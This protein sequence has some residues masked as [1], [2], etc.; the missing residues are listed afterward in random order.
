MLPL[1]QNDSDG[2][3]PLCYLSVNCVFIDVSKFEAHQHNVPRC[4]ITKHTQSPAPPPPPLSPTPP[5][6]TPIHKH[7]TPLH[8]LAHTQSTYRYTYQ[9]RMSSPLLRTLITNERFIFL[10]LEHIPDDP[11][12]TSVLIVF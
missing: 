10:L 1:T 6:H 7:L 11:E 8:P 9:Y 3:R 4:T 2:R 12:T 5:P